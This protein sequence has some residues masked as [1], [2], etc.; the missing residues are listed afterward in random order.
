[1]NREQQKYLITRIDNEYDTKY[2]RIEEERPSRYFDSRSHCRAIVAN[3]LKLKYTLEEI[4]AKLTTS[5]SLYAY[6][7]FDTTPYDTSK[8][9]YQKPYN[10]RQEKL[11]N[12]VLKLIDTIMLGDAEEA[13]AMLEAF[14]KKD[15]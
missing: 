15:F 3:K 4:Y 10:D 12:E 6:E 14:L 2:R 7:L 1:M 5:S 8:A 9:A 11:T 13:M